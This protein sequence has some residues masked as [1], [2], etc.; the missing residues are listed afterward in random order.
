MKERL[1]ST[2]VRHE[3]ALI[4]G[5]GSIEFKLQDIDIVRFIFKVI[6]DLFRVINVYIE[7]LVIPTID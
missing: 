3:K 6:N 2:P 1:D 5:F 7:T 4:K